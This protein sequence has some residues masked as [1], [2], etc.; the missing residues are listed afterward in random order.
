MRSRKKPWG[1][2]EYVQGFVGDVGDLTKLVM[3]KEGLRPQRNV[4][5]A[6]RHE[7]SDCLWS[8]LVLAAE[9]DVDLESAFRAT[10]VGL[11]KKLKPRRRT[12][13]AQTSRAR[14]D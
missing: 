6:L 5:A 13:T 1:A 10:M 3:A 14:R 8:I 9:Y 7:L 12:R 11:R 2:S 4:D